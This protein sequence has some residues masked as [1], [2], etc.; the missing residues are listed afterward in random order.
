M[1]Q[2]SEKRSYS[3]ISSRT[4]SEAW[5]GSASS[6]ASASTLPSIR[7][8]SPHLNTA[9]TSQPAQQTRAAQQKNM[10]AADSLPLRSAAMALD[11]DVLR[12][13]LTQFI[14]TKACVNASDEDVY[15]RFLEKQAGS[16]QAMAVEQLDSVRVVAALI[17]EI[18][19]EIENLG[20][21]GLSKLHSVCWIVQAQARPAF[22][23]QKKWVVCSVSSLTTSECVLLGDSSEWSVDVSYMAFLRMLWMVSHIDSIEYSKY[24]LFV[25][26]R[27]SSEKT[28]DS[29]R[30]IEQSDVYVNDAHITAYMFALRYVCATLLDTIE[31]Y[32]KAG[33]RLA[34]PERAGPERA[35]SG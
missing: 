6:S 30:C 34:G 28:I 21:C 24:V 2:L 16:D 7:H 20:I 4:C 11:D 13:A 12:A 14:L 10:A 25:N 29:L 22:R 8:A 35:S 19:G 15:M 9:E 26:S 31:T 18:N 5:A 1:T 33:A 27:P 23:V 17:T 32:T 3:T